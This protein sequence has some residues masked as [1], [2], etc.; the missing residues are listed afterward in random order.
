MCDKVV[1]LGSFSKHLTVSHKITM[2]EYFIIM[3]LDDK[4]VFEIPD[5]LC[6]VCDGPVTHMLRKVK[7]PL[8]VK[9]NMLMDEYYFKYIRDQI[10]SDQ[11]ENKKIVD[12]CLQNVIKRMNNVG[13]EKAGEVIENAEG[14]RTTHSVV[15]FGEDGE[16]DMSDDAGGDALLGYLVS[17]FK[18]EQGIDLGK[19]AIALQRV[20]EA[21]KKAKVE[22]SSAAQTDINLP[23]ITIDASGPKHMYIKL[24]RAKFEQIVGDLIKMVPGNDG[25]G[26]G[27]METVDEN[28]S[29]DEA[30]IRGEI[31]EEDIESIELSGG[32]LRLDANT[33]GE[34]FIVQRTKNYP[35]HDGFSWKKFG[36]KK[37]NIFFQQFVCDKR[38]CE[39]LKKARM[40]GSRHM[41]RKYSQSVDKMQVIYLKK[42]T[43]QE[44]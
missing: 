26:F 17:E 39:G 30:D 1:F 11:N 43:C 34:S 13:E 44:N 23:N 19:D 25:G 15:A 29:S 36:K 21:A 40:F 28:D 6:M 41:K 12:F 32:E 7:S 9:H 33:L 35:N 31:I 27:V 38:N 3:E 24:S 2:E 16:N 14:A 5:M 20:R 10:I 22:L 37:K 4:T 42:H 8:W 18:K